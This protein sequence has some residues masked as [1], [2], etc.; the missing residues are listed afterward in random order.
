MNTPLARR[1]DLLVSVCFAEL[2]PLEEAL[3]L[4][5]T[6]A[7]QLNARYR[8]WEVLIAVQP[9]GASAFEEQLLEQGNVRLLSVRHGTPYYRCRA[10]VASE[11]IGDVVALTA[12]EELAVLD[13]VAL[14]DASSA[15]GSIVMGRRQSGGMLDPV[16]RGLG[17]SAGF[18]ADGRGMLSTAF[19]RSLLNRIL[20]HPDRQLALRF[21]PVDQGIG[22]EWQDSHTA[23]ARTF[24]QHNVERRVKLVHR[25]LVSSAPR[26]LTLV[27]LLSLLVVASATAFTLYAIVVWLTFKNVQPGWFTTSFVLG[28][29]A[30]FLGLAIF[31]LS[32]GIQKV[33]ETISIDASD[34]VIGERSAVDLFDQ[35]M[36]ELNVETAG[37]KSRIVHARVSES[38]TLPES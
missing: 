15:S 12:F 7:D 19:P 23:E 34:D 20:A 27:A 37:N 32:I 14:V 31:G 18:R 1:E 13:I 30:G 4:L 21:P 17:R 35:V 29:T 36:Q 9:D 25:L 3:P 6:L 24:R 8:Y 10:M 38:P 16:M 26:V 33:L 11:A 28:L 5:R 22:V 2:P